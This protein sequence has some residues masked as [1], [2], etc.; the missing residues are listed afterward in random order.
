MRSLRRWKPEAQNPTSRTGFLRSLRFRLT[1]SYVLFF[2]VLLIG[3]GLLFQ[4]TLQLGMDD[5]S[6]AALE[7]EWGAAKGY[8]HIE[9]GKP[10]WIADPTDPEE[11][12]IVERLRHV[13]ILADYNGKVL[14]HSQTYDSIGIDSPQEIGRILNLPMPEIH[15][16]RD[17]EG[18]PYM[19]KAGYVRG[20]KGHPYFFALGRSI[21]GNERTVANF[22][23]NYFLI[24]PGL[25]FVAGLLGWALAG[26]AIRP[27]NLVA[28]TAQ[29][30]TGSNLSLRIPRRN[31]NDEL[32][33]LIDAFNRMTVRLSESFD[34]IRQFS[35]DVSHELR[36]PLTAIRGQ[37]E[38][39][40]FT[41]EKPDQ[42][43]DAMVNALEDVEKLS[44]IVRALLL[45]SQAESGQLVLQKT[46][47]DLGE[48]VAD[49]VDQFQIPADEKNVKLTATLEPGWMANA[50]RTQVERMI[51]NLLSNAL[52]YTPKGGKVHVSVHRDPEEGWIRLEVEDNGVGIPAENLPHIFDRFYRVRN[53]QTNYTQGLGLGLSFV[54]WIVSAHD[55][56]IQV[57]SKPG[58][59]SRFI[60]RLPAAMALRESASEPATTTV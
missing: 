31:A 34:Q 18:V 3:I 5:D 41:A 15:V 59:G 32:D 47:L 51:S 21:Q 33:N 50:D 17:A 7:E 53:A 11:A 48:V 42:F 29:E 6:R 45:L 8:L 25:I 23:K 43:R 58:A 26:R 22:T 55:G 10:V 60:V 4:K 9:G 39:A 35:T 52:K 57:E 13:Y 14:E 40:L 37:L 24:L 30:I 16:R 38:V 19:I 36:T 1:L 54:S 56:A 49:V 44:S 12:Y 28:A 2:S 20:D 46:R 27:L